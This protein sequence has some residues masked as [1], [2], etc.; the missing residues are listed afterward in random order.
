[1]EKVGHILR[2]KQRTYSFEFFPP[3]TPQ[4]LQKFWENASRLASL[5][6]DWFSVTYGA[7]G[8]TRDLTTDLVDRIQQRFHI[9]AIHHLTCIGHTEVELRTKISE[10][11]SRNICNVLALRGDIPQGVDQK[12]YF[13][14]DYQ[15]TYQLVKLLRE[16]GDYFSIGIAG[17]PEGHINCPDKETDAQYLKIKVNAGADFAVTQFFLDNADYFQY[18]ARLRRL[19]VEVK[20]IPGILPITDYQSLVNFCTTCGAN[21]PQQVHDIFRPLEGNPKALYEA[22]LS[23]ALDQCSELLEK[24]APGLHF[25]TLNK[26]EPTCEIVNRLLNG[27]Y[28]WIW[29]RGFTTGCDWYTIIVKTK[30]KR[31][32][33]TMS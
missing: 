5:K 14:G 16:Q 26:A 6:P 18:V 21:I 4:G 13:M 20:I 25:Y 28:Q 33:F 29:S 19:G 27:N 10:M 7:G 12:T 30:E 1:M 2:Q 24:G 32:Q 31:N 23:F 11:K 9:P 8:S 17:F 3:K 22:G 15:Y